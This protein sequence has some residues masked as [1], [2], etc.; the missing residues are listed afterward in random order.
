MIWLQGLCNLGFSAETYTSIIYADSGR[1]RHE[2][3]WTAL[4]IGS[5]MEESPEVCIILTISN[6]AVIRHVLRLVTVYISYSYFL[7]FLS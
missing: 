2:R 5:K 3:L 1:D 7:A 4:A 6:V